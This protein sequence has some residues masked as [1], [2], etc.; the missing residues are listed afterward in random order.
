[1]RRDN[2]EPERHRRDRYRDDSYYDDDY[3]DDGSDRHH[4]LPTRQVVQKSKTGASFLAGLGIVLVTLVATFGVIVGIGVMSGRSPAEPEEPKEQPAQESS[5]TSS[6]PASEVLAPVTNID[7]N[8]Q[9]AGTATAAAT[10]TQNPTQTFFESQGA[11]SDASALGYVGERLNDEQKRLYLQLHAAISENRENVNMLEV[12]DEGSIK[13]AWEA[14]F[15]DHPEFFWLDGKYTYVYDPNGH[16]LTVQFGFC[17]PLYEM[18]NYRQMIESKVVAFQNSLPAG[19]SQYDIALKAYE[20]VIYNTEYDESAPY[21]QNM[22]SV[23]ANGRS[24]CAGYA[25]AYQ[26]LLH[27]SGMFCAFVQGNGRTESGAEESH[28][29]NMI[30]I[31]GT[32]A[33]VDTTWGDKN[34]KMTATGQESWGEI[35]Y[36]YFGMTTAELAQTGH[37]FSNP[38]MWPVCDSHNL[39]VYGRSGMLWDGYDRAAFQNVVKAHIANGL[40]TMEFQFTNHDA[41][42]ACMNDI[43]GNEESMEELPDWMDVHRAGWAYLTNETTM[44]GRFSW[45]QE[46]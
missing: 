39:N 12:Y 3:Y 15:A 4:R 44:T 9:S 46:R 14:I 41:W 30:C 45:W 36:A 18:S 43:M 33:F 1:M 20:Y 6:S 7:A 23:F 13:A 17:V 40:T 29:W 24:V 34:P 42:Q 2:R 8:G 27:R 22:L 19:A 31:D 38:E 25:R 26:Y 32:Y 35:R 16:T 10:V 21:N 28:G 37:S 11:L 5:N